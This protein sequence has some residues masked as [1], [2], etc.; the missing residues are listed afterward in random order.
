MPLFQPPLLVFFICKAFSKP[1][2]Y[3]HL[4]PASAKT[5]AAF[6]AFLTVVA[7]LAFPIFLFYRQQGISQDKLFK[8]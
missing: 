6:A 5:A 3:F 8:P 1:L 4:F 7:I 2:M